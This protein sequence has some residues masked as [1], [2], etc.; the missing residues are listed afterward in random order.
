MKQGCSLE[1]GKAL[2]LLGVDGS[3]FLLYHKNIDKTA[4]RGVIL[5]I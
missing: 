4:I 3:L 5:W 1:K 2:V